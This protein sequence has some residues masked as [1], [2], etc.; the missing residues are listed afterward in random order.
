MRNLRHYCHLKKKK[1]FTERF[2]QT[3]THKTYD[4]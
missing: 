2:E 1:N 3:F 4:N